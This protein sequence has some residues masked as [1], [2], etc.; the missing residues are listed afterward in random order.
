M[1]SKQLHKHEA[2]MVSAISVLLVEDDHK[3][4]ALI[5][6]YLVT[7]GFLV[8]QVFRGDEAPDRIKKECP[9]LVILDLMLPGQDG[10]AVCRAVRPEYQGPILMLTAR[11]D[12]MDQVAG[13]EMGADDYVKKPVLPRVLLARARAL[14][15][16]HNKAVLPVSDPE[17]ENDLTFGQLHICQSARRV[18]LNGI[19]LDFSTAEFDLLCFLAG[20]AG[21]I[22][23]RDTLYQTL[24]GY[25]Y[26]GLDRS[27]DVA[28]S[29]LRK[30]LGDDSKTPFRIKTVWGKGYLFV[31]D[32]W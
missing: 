26:D 8:S 3:L 16:R 32:A 19:Q 9:D 11:D 1:I 31:P 30:K 27:M 24:K 13:L 6:E 17:T 23:S 22:V 18:T 15:R 14:L 12:D 2:I 28:M 7:Q 20:Q 10:F 21:R 4:S 5:K 25:D 29:R